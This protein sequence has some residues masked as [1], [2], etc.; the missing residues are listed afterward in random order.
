MKKKKA[1]TIK[2][3]CAILESCYLANDHPYP[4]GLGLR[5]SIVY[6]KAFQQLIKLTPVKEKEGGMRYVC[7]WCL[8]WIYRDKKPRRCPKCDAILTPVKGK[9]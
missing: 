9:E 4:M 3:C 5:Q 7:K 8:T 6:L 2:E 1:L